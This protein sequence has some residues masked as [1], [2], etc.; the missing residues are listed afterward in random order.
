[1]NKNDKI[2]IKLEICKDENSNE[3]KLMTHFDSNA[4]NFFKENDNFFWMPTIEEKD[5]INE[6]FNLIP[7]NTNTTI[8]PTKKTPPEPP[9]PENPPVPDTN[10]PEKKE[11]KPP[12]PEHPPQENSQ[13][14]YNKPPEKKEEKPPH[15]GHPPQDNPQASDTN[16]PWQK[17]EQKPHPEP[18]NPETPRLIGTPPPEKKE[19]KP[20]HPEH[21]PQDNPQ[22]LNNKPPEKKEEKPKFFHSPFGKKKEENT[23][24]EPPK[25]IE[26]HEETVFEVTGEEVKPEN[27]DDADK[28]EGDVFVKADDNAIK[29]ALKKHEENDNSIVEADEKTIIEKV[30]SQKKKGRWSKDI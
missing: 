10:P 22:L 27:K 29:E 3:L 13:L 6:A 4:P 18:S 24:P 9:N 23:L 14:L 20:P 7:N 5:F 16:P 11:E 1:M 15:P 30:L 28:K 25:K 19:E 8:S 21:P 17:E 2:H 12:H 26:T